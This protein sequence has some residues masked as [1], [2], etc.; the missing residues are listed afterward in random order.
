MRHR[1]SSVRPELPGKLCRV[2]KAEETEAED[3]MVE[4][5]EI[6]VHV[7]AKG[8]HPTPPNPN[9]YGVN[10]VNGGGN[11]NVRGVNSRGIGVNDSRH[12]KN[13]GAHGGQGF[14]PNPFHPQYVQRQKFVHQD[15][16]NGGSSG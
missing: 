6:W 4:T 1:R 7:G 11:G 2:Y 10:G 15:H 12:G 9:T 5:A 13:G 16:H 8:S 3:T 14:Q